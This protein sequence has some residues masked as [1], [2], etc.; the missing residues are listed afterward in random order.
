[1]NPPFHTIAD[2][3]NHGNTFWVRDLTNYGEI[4]YSKAVIIADFGIGTDSPII[5]YYDDDSESPRVMYL[6]WSGSGS[7]ICHS[8]VCTHSSFEEFANDTGLLDK[9]NE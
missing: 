9:L 7:D 2:E 3:V 6:K 8:W 5:L 1:M 4:D